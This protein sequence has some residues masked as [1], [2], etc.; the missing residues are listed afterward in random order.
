[1]AYIL[2][3][4]IRIMVNPMHPCPYSIL[5]FLFI[6]PITRGPSSAPT[7]PTIPRTIDPLIGVMKKHVSV[8]S[9]PS[10]FKFSIIVFEYII[11]A[12]NPVF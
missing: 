1:M 8:F 11:I 9:H 2:K 3:I 6:L 5:F 12:F 7:N 10:G 4:A